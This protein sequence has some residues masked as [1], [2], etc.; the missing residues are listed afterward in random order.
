MAKYVLNVIQP[1]GGP[2]PE[3]DL[4]RIMRDV[5]AVDQEMKRST[6]AAS[7]SS[8]LPT[9]TRP[10]SGPATSR[11]RRRSRSRCDRSRKADARRRPGL[12]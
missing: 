4:E 5:D 9:S 1:T 7:R 12:P 2:P 6:S 10:S 3:G 11:G 8:T